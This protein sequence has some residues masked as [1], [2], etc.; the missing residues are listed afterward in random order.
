MEEWH[1]M[2]DFI[3]VCEFCGLRGVQGVGGVDNIKLS[4]GIN[5]LN[6]ANQK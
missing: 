2:F 4:A 3:R 5:D 6:I 1:T